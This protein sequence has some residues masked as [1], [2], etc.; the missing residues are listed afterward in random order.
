MLLH[1]FFWSVPDVSLGVVSYTSSVI[2]RAS[3]CL[4]VA[5]CSGARH[6]DIKARGIQ[7][8]VPVDK[9]STGCLRAIL[10]ATWKFAIGRTA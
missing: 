2:A 7:S 6:D 8:A 4:I 9:W 1:R 5:D 10:F 3:M